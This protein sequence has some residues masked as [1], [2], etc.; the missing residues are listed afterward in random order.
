MKAFTDELVEYLESIINDACEDGSGLPL[1]ALHERAT[2]V[3]ADL[4]PQ[5]LADCV[6]T[7]LSATVGKRQGPGGGYYMIGVEAKKVSNAGE[8]TNRT[9]TEDEIATVRREVEAGLKLNNNK[10]I[11][12]GFVLGRLNNPDTDYLRGA[13][14][15]LPE[16]TVKKGSGICWTPQPAPEAAEAT[17]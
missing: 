9:Y 5:T 1:K 14:Q 16:F 7:C 15:S 6:D 2:E 17:Q 12:M 11:Q 4:K 8:P 3:S 10:G 13:L